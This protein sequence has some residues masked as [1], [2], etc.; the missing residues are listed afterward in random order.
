VLQVNAAKPQRRLSRILAHI[1]GQP[2]DNTVLNSL[3][4]WVQSKDMV[5]VY[6]PFKPTAKTT[7]RDPKLQYACGE[8]SLGNAQYIPCTEED[9]SA[10]PLALAT[11]FQ[12]HLVM[13]ANLF[14][15]QVTLCV[16]PCAD[17]RSG[18]LEAAKSFQ[19]DTVVLAHGD[20]AFAVAMDGDGLAVAV[21]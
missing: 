3:A 19:C 13:C 11:Q 17:L 21:V 18:I 15:E 12:T 5:V 16:E 20:T 9:E 6:Y 10:G 2:T 8:D 7:A 1:R 14:E 4:R